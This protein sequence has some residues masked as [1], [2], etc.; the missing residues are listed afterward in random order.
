[1]H[2][3]CFI[4]APSIHHP[5]PVYVLKGREGH[6][7]HEGQSM[8]HLCPAP[9]IPRAPSVPRPCCIYAVSMPYP[10]L[11]VPRPFPVHAPSMPLSLPPPF[12]LFSPSPP[13]P[14]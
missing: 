11:S 12:P 9:S 1:M 6:E 3:L 10:A 5:F 4:Y 7:G 2:Y 13:P 8:H 14:I